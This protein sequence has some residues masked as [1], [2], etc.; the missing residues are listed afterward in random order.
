[1]A[2]T[3]LSRPPATPTSAATSLRVALRVL[4]PLIAEGPVIRRPAMTALAS[5]LRWDQGVVDALSDL[6]ERHGE[7][8]VPLRILGRRA[9][10][11][12]SR[13]D[14]GRVLVDAPELFTAANREKRAALRHF[15]PDAVLIST[16]PSRDQRRDFNEQVLD[17]GQAMHRL[18]APLTRVVEEEVAQLLSPGGVILDWP[19]FARTH[20]RIVRRV[21]LGDRARDDVELSRRLDCLRRRANWAY[22]RPRARR[23][24]DGFQARLAEYLADA[25]PDSL[26]AVIASTS[27][28]PDVRPYGQVPHW[29]FAFDAVGSSVF[30]ALAALAVDDRARSTVETERHAGVAVRPGLTAALLDAV[31]LW[32]TTVVILR[33]TTVDL[34]WRGVRLPAGS[35]VVIVSS[36]FHRDAATVPAAHRLDLQSWLNGA[37]DSDPGIVPF[38]AGPVRCPGRDLVTFTGATLLATILARHDVTLMR[39]RLDPAALPVSLDHFRI[40]FRVVRRG[41]GGT[42]R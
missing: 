41:R 22:A 9:A 11:V 16:G 38:S 15:Q 21:V 26:A 18:A 23:R 37:N 14:V 42:D 17:I 12:L 13:Y 6:R 33:D 40:R 28:S 4:L 25:E 24:R 1:M 35:A 10:L 30:R 5:L 36:F 39:P 7:G 8:P 20:A 2:T 3:T 27:G 29:L 34:D 31:R 32:P 19:R